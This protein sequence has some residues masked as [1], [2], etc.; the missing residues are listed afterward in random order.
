MALLAGF[1]LKHPTSL[2]LQSSPGFLLTK[3]HFF[4]H[5][6]LF[7]AVLLGVQKKKNY[8]IMFVNMFRFR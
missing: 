6:I 2:M 4:V 1:M 8:N 3:R 7:D 5:Q